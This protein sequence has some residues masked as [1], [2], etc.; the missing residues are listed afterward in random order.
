MFHFIYVYLGL[1]L[2]HYYNIL[3]NRNIFILSRFLEDSNL[4]SSSKPL[5]TASNSTHIPFS[6]TFYY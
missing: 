3:F 1:T 5:E 6:T 4:I 2:L